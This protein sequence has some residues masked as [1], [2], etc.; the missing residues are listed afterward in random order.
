M[1]L[2]EPNVSEPSTAAME[3]AASTSAAQ[4]SAADIALT[5]TESLVQ[6]MAATVDVGGLGAVVDSIV[7]SSA[8]NASASRLSGSL[9]GRSMGSVKSEML[10]RYGGNAASEKSVAMALDWLARHQDSSGGWTFGHSAVCRGECKG[11]GDF[12]QAVNGATALALLPFL[13]AG[14]THVEGKYKTTVLKGLTFLIRNMKQTPGEIPHGSWHE[15]KGNMYSH[16]LASIVVC[17]A[18]AMTRDPKLLQ[19]AQLAVNFIVHAQDPRGGGWRYAPK[20]PGDTSVVGWQLMALKSGSM[21][22]LAVPADCLRKADSF[23]NS[24]SV[25]E[26]AFYGYD[27][28]TSEAAN[29]PGTTAV[30]LLC[31]MYLGWS[32]DKPGMKAGVEMLAKRGPNL[33][34]LYYSYYATQVLRQYGGDEWNNWNKVMRDS[35]IKAQETEGHSA[36]SW[37]IEKG[38]HHQQGGRLYCTALSTMILEVYYR[39]MPLYSEKSSD[40]KFEF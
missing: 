20:Q 21:G 17:E 30:G 38:A 32:K 39:H 12:H 8:L 13:G 10:E 37:Y 27:K 5:N 19:P 3:T 2:S 18:Y 22:N 25:N 9:M 7:P 23:L 35:L 36:G 16:G 31:R 28:A 4:F 1:Q 33:N 26:G 34:D 40:D 6:P 15:D 24:I 11:D 29:R 14:Q